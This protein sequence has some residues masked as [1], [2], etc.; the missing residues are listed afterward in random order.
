MESGERAGGQHEAQGYPRVAATGEIHPRAVETVSGS[1]IH[2]LG[3]AGVV[4]DPNHYRGK[5]PARGE[6]SGTLDHVTPRG[7]WSRKALHEGMDLSVATGVLC[8][9]ENSVTE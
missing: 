2:R 7:M 6:Q 9:Q 5:V 8:A 4:G 1:F 3:H